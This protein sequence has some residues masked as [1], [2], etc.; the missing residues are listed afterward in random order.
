MTTE[1]DQ[2]QSTA[3]NALRTRLLGPFTLWKAKLTGHGSAHPAFC[4][5]MAVA[6]AVGAASGPHHFIEETWAGF[7]LIATLGTLVLMVPWF[8]MNE[9]KAHALWKR[10]PKQRKPVTIIPYLAD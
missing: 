2:I 7:M 1:A 5:T 3:N 4:A 10:T 9:S 6:G 8:K